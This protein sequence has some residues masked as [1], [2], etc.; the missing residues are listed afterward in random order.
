MSLPDSGSLEDQRQALIT[1]IDRVQPQG[2]FR[3]SVT[4]VFDGAGYQKAQQIKIIFSQEESADS[5]IK[6]FV[7]EAVHKK[8]IIVVTDD[9]AVQYAVKALGAQICS[10]KE[11]LSKGRAASAKF[12]TERSK[13]E[14][15][16]N[17][18]KVIEEDITSEFENIWLK[19]KSS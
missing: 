16:K 3:N 12:K 14:S 11:F 10:V 6:Q 7:E 18:S 5:K 17:I 8:T 9:R 19:K 1:F 2:S 13:A 15:I 4:I